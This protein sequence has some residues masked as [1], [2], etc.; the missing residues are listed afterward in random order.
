M[1]YHNF[2]QILK[3]EKIKHEKLIIHTIDISK[4]VHKML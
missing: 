1:V 2:V 4:E 3:K